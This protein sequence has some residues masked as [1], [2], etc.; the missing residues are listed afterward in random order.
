M[1]KATKNRQYLCLAMFFALC[2]PLWAVSVPDWVHQAASQTLPTYPPDANAVVLLAQEDDSVNSPGEYVEHVRRAVRILRPEGRD[3]GTIWVYLGHG[4]KLLSLL[5]MLQ[6]VWAGKVGLRRLL[7]RD[8]SGPMCAASRQ[9]EGCQGQK[10][11]DRNPMHPRDLPH[12]R[13]YS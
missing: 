7:R 2:T 9:Q 13:N 4:E 1:R 6:A 12:P 8:R 10:R 11:A 3:Q 5:L